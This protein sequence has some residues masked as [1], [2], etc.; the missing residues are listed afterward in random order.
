VNT[1]YTIAKDARDNRGFTHMEAADGTREALIM[2]KW[3]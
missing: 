3:A 1:I 2:P